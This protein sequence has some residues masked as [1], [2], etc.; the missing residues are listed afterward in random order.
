MLIHKDKAYLQY[1]RTEIEKKLAEI[2]LEL[3]KKTSLYPLKQGVKFLQWRFI[4]TETGGVRLKMSGKKQGRERRRLAKLAEKE[5]R[6]EV[7]AGTTYNSF[8]SWKANAD[9]GDTYYQVKRM[10]EYCEDLERKIRHGNSTGT[11]TEIGA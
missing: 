2:H 10:Q 6:G 4:L 5:I 9:R 3:N 7:K 11:V 8:V 1:C